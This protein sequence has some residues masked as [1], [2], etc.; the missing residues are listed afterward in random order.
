MACAVMF[1]GTGSDVGKSLLV[2][3]L[4]RALSNRG[5]KVRPFKPQNMSN[6]AAV[7][8]EGGEIGRAQALQA[9]ACRIRP[10]TD[11][12]PILL[13][14]QTDLGSQVIVQG[15]IWG[16]TTTG[17]YWQKRYEL[18]STVLE[19]FQ[20]LSS[21]ADIVLVE[22]AGSPAEVN[23]RSGD[24][25]NMGFAEAADIPVILIGDIDRGGVIASI[26]GTAHLISLQERSRIQGVLINKFRGNLA[27]FESGL[28][29]IEEKS[30][31]PSLGVVPFFP[32][33]RKLPDE[34]A[35]AVQS[36]RSP[37]GLSQRSIRI[38]V[39]LISRI[40]NFDDMDPLIAESDVELSFIH[41]GEVLPADCDLVILPGSKATISDLAFLREQGW[42][43]DLAAH[44]RRGG[45]VVGI[46]GGYQMMGMTIS[47]PD[48]IEGEPMTVSG[49]KLLPVDTVLTP[50][51]KLMEVSGCDAAGN[52]FLEGYEMHVGVTT[53]RSGG[54]NVMPMLYLGDDNRPEGCLIKGGQVSGCY[55]H[56]LFS[57]DGFRN[58]FLSR[59]KSRTN[60]DFSY[61]A[62]IDATLDALANHLEEHVDIDR[63]LEI[64]GYKPEA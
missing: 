39:L 53:V 64:A 15:K 32:A 63:I 46:C 4:A 5:F 59:I 54:E 47:D 40:S 25:A 3:G 12:N 7:T 50:E 1:Q 55:L 8:A 43:V 62:E 41:P 51:K 61:E 23:L 33:A 11:M 48:G 34:D 17:N 2:A 20:R 16:N 28:K 21:D 57:S 30:G 14:P 60:H 10:S 52:T 31:F 44:I 24:I 19:S 42:D 37:T 38:A 56:G 29:I 27:L 35:V 58:S 45:N 26:V 9:R 36:S 6:N 22:G 49:L 18:M 13:K